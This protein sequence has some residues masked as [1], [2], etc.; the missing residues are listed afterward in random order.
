MTP[1][2]R[3]VKLQNN[4][5]LIQFS[6]S[7]GLVDFV[8]TLEGRQWHSQTKTWSAPAT[9]TNIARLLG[10]DFEAD[11]SLVKYLKEKEN[12]KSA[13]NIKIPG[14]KITLKNYQAEGLAGINALDDRALLGDEMGLGKTAQAIAWLEQN[15]EARP[16][17]I[18]CPASLKDMWKSKIKAWMT[19]ELP[20]VLSGKSPNT[21][22]LFKQ[23]KVGN[24]HGPIYILNYDIIGNKIKTEERE[25]GTK[26]RKELEGTGWVDFL[27]QMKPKAIVV[28]ECHNTK[29]TKTQKATGVL[30]L[31]SKI[32]MALCMSG[33]PIT[34]RPVEFWPIL[35]TLKPN[36]FKNFFKFAKKY[37]NAKSNGF[38]WDFTGSSNQL[39]LNKLLAETVMIRRLKKDV[40]KELPD[41]QREV[42]PLDISASFRR[43]YAQYE[44][45]LI[46]T[47]GDIGAYSKVK[48]ICAEAKIKQVLEWIENFLSSGEKLIAVAHNHIMVDAIREKFSKRTRVAEITGQTK[49]NRQE[50]EDIFQNDPNCQLIIISKSGKEGHTLTAAS[51]MCF[52]QLFDTPGEMAQ[53]E[54]R[55]HRIGQ[56]ANKCTYWYL[57]A[58]NTIEEDQAVLLDTKLTNL[59]EILDGEQ[60][61]DEEML[62]Y[63]LD[64]AKKRQNV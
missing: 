6:Y 59:K 14:L 1:P 48:T 4:Q 9:Q 45:E 10:N 51:N 26:K 42:I 50:Q 57:V 55:I 40:L 44:K 13:K 21:D 64:K 56:D 16:A 43:L 31:I 27:A 34:N 36:I 53:T 52:T 18:V 49:G 58:E 22:D 8:K 19:K 60:I 28:D 15:K 32:D 5:L 3:T 7:S 2:S 35:S 30:K 61:A 39:E 33:T 25:D 63:L 29:N 11:L 47:K 46:D 24:P 41:K 38:G 62:T 54:D 20:I 37:C 23:T 12:K 17:I